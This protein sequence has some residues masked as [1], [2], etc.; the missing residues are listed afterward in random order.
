MRKLKIFGRTIPLALVLTIAIAAL[1][2]AALLN[3]YGTITGQVTSE[4]SVL[5]DGE[6]V[7]ASLNLHY[8]FNGMTTVAGETFVETHS[9]ENQA[10]VPAEVEFKTTCRNSAG[11]DDGTRTEMDI[12]WSDYNGDNCDG[13]K[14]RYYK[15]TDYYLYE[16]LI[17]VTSGGSTSTVEVED[18]GN[19]VEFT[20]DYND[21]E[22]TDS[23]DYKNRNGAV[24]VLIATKNSSGDWNIDYQIH[25]N[26]GT[27]GNYN[28]GT[29][30]YSDYYPGEGFH[31]WKTSTENTE[32]SDLDW[33]SASGQRDLNVN[34]D[35]VFT[36]SIE[37]GNNLD[38]DEVKFLVV[39]NYPS[40]DSQTYPA[41]SSAWTADASDFEMAELGSSIQEEDLN[42]VSGER[43]GFVVINEFAINLHPDTYTL[44]TNIAPV[45]A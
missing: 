12:D 22:I 36:V 19:S 33:V 6:S 42:L 7:D 43:L 40:G 9:L 32:V 37:K 18:K 4:Q 14:T 3:Y 41:V 24:A 26:D 13:I 1:G 35:G 45:T 28:P 20:V 16:D 25:N 44:T 31:G 34:T 10:N 30:L 38:A 15:L 11:S 29:W 5:V 8:G 21:S 27:D 23:G 17:K 39:N 2:S